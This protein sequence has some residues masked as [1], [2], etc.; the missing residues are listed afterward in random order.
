MAVTDAL[1]KTIEDTKSFVDTATEKMD[2]AS[3]LLD[4]D[5]AL[6]NQ[7]FKDYDE[8]KE[9]LETA[10]SDLTAAV[11]T[12]S[13]GVDAAADGNVLVLAGTVVKGIVQ[14]TDAMTRYAKVFADLKK[15]FDNYKKAVEHNVQVIQAF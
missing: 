12:L 4:E 13:D 1:A 14:I 10:K 3:K 11:E 7:A 8:I 9:L 6:V 15:K 5:V 2:K